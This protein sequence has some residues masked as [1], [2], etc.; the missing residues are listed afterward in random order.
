VNFPMAVTS[1]RMTAARG[2]VAYE[3]LPA[4]HRV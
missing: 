1:S 4:S 3:R 2:R